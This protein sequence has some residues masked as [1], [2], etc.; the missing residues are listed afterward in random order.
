[1]LRSNLLQ[2]SQQNLEETPSTPGINHLQHLA[3]KNQEIIKKR[4]L[5]KT[6]NTTGNIARAKSNSVGS[7]MKANRCISLPLL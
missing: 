4:L 2:S 3:Y 1:M 7:S 6:P 5:K